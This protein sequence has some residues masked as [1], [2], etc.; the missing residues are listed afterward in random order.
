MFKQD[1]AMFEHTAKQWTLNYAKEKDLSEQ[2][3]MITDMGFTAEQA[4]DALKKHDGNVEQAINHI[5]SS[6]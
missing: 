5:M 2:V 1:K 4:E 3:S 6:M